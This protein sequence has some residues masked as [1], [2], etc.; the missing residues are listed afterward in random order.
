MEQR[1]RQLVNLAAHCERTWR[2]QK[3]LQRRRLD[4][5]PGS[6][7]FD[8]LQTPNSGHPPQGRAVSASGWC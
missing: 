7:G 4:S 6:I 8:E 1:M 3:F 5:W 2:F